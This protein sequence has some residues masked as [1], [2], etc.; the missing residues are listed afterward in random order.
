MS[1]GVATAPEPRPT[2]AQHSSKGTEAARNSARQ[3]GPTEPV[4][5]APAHAPSSE[6][7]PEVLG[8]SPA[9]LHRP[10]FDQKPP[11]WGRDADAHGKYGVVTSVES[12]ATR[13]GVTILE[14]GGNA[15]DAAIATAF[16]LAV[17]H[18]SAANIGGG[19]FLLVKNQDRLEAIDFREDSPAGLDVGRFWKMIDQ[20]GH[21]ADSIGIPGT[22]AG[23][24][25]AHERHGR[26]PWQQLVLPAERLAQGGYKLGVRQARTL[27][28][29]KDHLLA[30]EVAAAAFFEGKTPKPAGT[31][32][33]RPRLALSLRR[34]RKQGPRGF[35]EGPTARD[36][37]K[38]GA[39]AF[40]LSDLKNYRAKLR[41]PLFFDFGEYRVVTMPP[42]SGG[43]VALAAQLRMLDALSIQAT[44]P[45][46]AARSHLIAE[47]SRRAQV[48]RQLFV[49]APEA[50]NPE[51]E[52]AM[53]LRVLDPQTW[54]APH[55]ISPKNA[56][57]SS[58]LDPSYDKLTKESEQ[59]TH[60][61]VIDGDG[62]MVSL[63][64]TLS[65]SYGSYIFTQETG[66]VLNNSVASFAKFGKNTPAPA[67]RTVS[68]MA[69]T[70]VFLGPH[71]L[72]LGTPGGDTIPGTLCQL[73]LRLALD[74]QTLAQAVKSPRFHQGFVPQEL[75]M[76][77]YA[78]LSR[79]L[80]ASLRQMGHDIFFARTTQGDANIAALVDGHPYAVF[81]RREG[82]LALGAST[83]CGPSPERE[84]VQ[85]AKDG[86]Q[87]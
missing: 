31:I 83:C 26:L 45:E 18:P 32:I 68:S 33:Q 36:L 43:G 47:T 52:R 50:L 71:A 61:S 24:Y 56:T 84:V 2:H 82:G 78:P 54:L 62:N 64:L 5:V 58:Q 77:R 70:L 79:S 23:L 53:R 10:A 73:F 65:A 13:I 29:S 6:P 34:I 28:W 51:Q 57:L 40:Q 3:A 14:Q 12:T 20:G 74:G 4:G 30:S 72:V 55:P 76:E 60:L 27:V 59:T 66:I 49:V 1:S 11:A 44:Q 48:E 75:G 15:I 7:A 42:P 9:L 38:S 46:S 35:Y 87:R 81:D 85:A 22:V 8:P 19:G 67:R 39:G 80:Q 63:T 37:V 69:P 41:E 25:L 86:A 16:A 21:G 17:T